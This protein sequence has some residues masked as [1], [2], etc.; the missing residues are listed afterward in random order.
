MRGKRFNEDLIHAV[1]LE[2]GEG[3]FDTIV[4]LEAGDEQINHRI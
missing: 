2:K 1:I 4:K 3:Q